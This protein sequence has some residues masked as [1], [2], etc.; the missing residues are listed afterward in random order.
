MNEDENN[1][2]I[3]AIKIL[4]LVRKVATKNFIKK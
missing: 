3:N 4:Y 1:A 2:T